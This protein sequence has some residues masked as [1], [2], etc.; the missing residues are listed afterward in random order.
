MPDVEEEE[1]AAPEAPLKLIANEDNDDNLYAQL[2]LTR[3][4]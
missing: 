1:E 2:L 3:E 4:G